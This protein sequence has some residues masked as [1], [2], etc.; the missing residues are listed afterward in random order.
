M[1]MSKFELFC[2]NDDDDVEGRFLSIS[3]KIC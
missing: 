3:G 2:E 1:S